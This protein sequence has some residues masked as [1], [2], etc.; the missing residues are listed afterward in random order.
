[1]KKI[2]VDA[3]FLGPKSENRKFFKET[4]DFLMDEHIHWRRDF[5]PEDSPAITLEE[6]EQPLHKALWLICKR[7]LF[8]NPIAAFLNK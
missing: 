4:L 1:M 8:C 2:N 5:H 7:I 6:Q 3:L